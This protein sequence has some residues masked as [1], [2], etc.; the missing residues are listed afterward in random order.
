M[1]FA[2]A[3]TTKILGGSSSTTVPTLA[4][5]NRVEVRALASTFPV[6]T[7]INILAAKA[8]K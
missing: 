2:I 6:A 5:G 4:L 1:T 8:T 7:K 3:T